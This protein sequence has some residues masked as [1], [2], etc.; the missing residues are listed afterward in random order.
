[1]CTC[2]F[3]IRVYNIPPPFIRI[4]CFHGLANNM[5]PLEEEPK[6][7]DQ[8]EQ[9]SNSDEV[10]SENVNRGKIKNYTIKV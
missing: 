2:I 4:L 5:E 6:L 9:T 3:T 7:A 8:A 1:M 10:I